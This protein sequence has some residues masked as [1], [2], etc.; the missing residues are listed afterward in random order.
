MLATLILFIYYFWLF[1]MYGSAMLTGLNRL[2][3]RETLAAL[4]IAMAILLGMCVISVLAS[5]FNLFLSLG[6]P[7]QI[8]VFVGG[9][10]IQKKLSLLRDFKLPSVPTWIW[11]LLSM[12]G[13]TALEISTHRSSVSDTA[14][15]HAQTI[16]WFETYAAVPGLGNLHHRLAFNSSWLVLNAALSFASFDFRSFHLVSGFFFLLVQLFFIR[17]LVD[18]IGGEISWSVFFKTL[19]IPLSFYLFSSVVSSPAY[20]MPV[21]LLTWVIIALWLETTES[22]ARIAGHDL[23]IFVLS[24]YAVTIKLSALP[25]LFF[26]AWILITKTTSGEKRTVAMFFIIAAAILF[27]W[28]VRSVILSGYLVFPLSQLDLFSFDWKIPPD[29]VEGI[30]QSITAFARLPGKDWESALAMRFSEWF[31]LWFDNLT[32]NQRGLFIL[33]S[34]SPLVLLL[35]KLRRWTLVSRGQF[36]GWFIAFAGFLFWFVSAPDVRFGYGFLAGIVLMLASLGLLALFQ[37]IES[38]TRLSK[39]IILAAVLLFQVYSFAFS[40]EPSTLMKR[41]VYPMDY[42]RSRAEPCDLNNATVYCRVEGG[43]CNYESFPCIP[44]PRPKVEL[45]G[46]SFQ[47]GFRES[48]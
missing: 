36:F 39:P 6:L 31:P 17:G 1:S 22:E 32:F 18:L 3:R 43:Q 13:L 21:A 2:L 12:V 19:S 27:P 4:P 47:S 41:V 48:P 8:L 46:D 15:Y 28:M 20:D 26:P 14:L 44:S 7:F 23:T 5:T 40:F 29:Q 9:V 42:S 11:V 10:I 38:Q 16:R 35:A 33:A 45:R 25:L 24:V 37:K 34:V 30:R